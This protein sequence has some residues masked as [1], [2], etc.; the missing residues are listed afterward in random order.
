MKIL[1]I[2]IK[3]YRSCNDLMFTPHEALSVLIGPNGSGKTNILSAIKLLSAIYNH[4]SHGIVKSD[5]ESSISELK[6]WYKID[7]LTIT[8]LAKLNIVTNEQ[9]QDEIISVDENWTIASIDKETNKRKSK[10]VSFPSWLL[11]DISRMQG[12][13]FPGAR[14]DIRKH[15]SNFL[16]SAGVDDAVLDTMSKL[17]HLVTRIRYYSASQFTNPTTCPIS[18]EVEGVDSRHRTGISITGHKKLLFDIYQE[19][20]K[21]SEEY[22][23]FLNIVGSDGVG[24]V[25]SIEFKEIVTSSSNYSVRTGGAVTKKEKTNQLVIPSFIISGNALSPNQ[26]SEGTFKTLA[27][28]FY[29]VTD[30]SSILMI[31]EPEV[32]IHHGLLKSIVELIS[33]YSEEKQIFVS[34]HSDAVLDSVDVDKVFKVSRI[35]GVGTKVNN[36]RKNMK[37]KELAALKMYLANEGSLGDYWKYG[38]LE[39]V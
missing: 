30:K 24:L 32:C 16:V 25:D 39:N 33:V 6:T 36:I 15:F 38:D 35:K 17:A 14:S 21:K 22:I 29:L 26:L 12:T 9:N 3:N 8:H 27:L 4:K 7:D 10:M 37:K 11:L 18:F 34:T 19:Y 31:E 28:V 2:S 20:Q 23:D 13:S 5:S 1:K